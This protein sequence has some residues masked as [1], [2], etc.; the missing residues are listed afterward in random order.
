MSDSLDTDL[1]NIFRD[2]VGEY[3]ETLNTLLMQIETAA[4]ADPESLRELNRVAHSMKGAS[5]AVGLKVIETIA[6][7]M[8]EVFAASMQHQ[9]KL[10]PDVCDLLYDGLDLIQTVVDGDENDEETLAH[11][12]MHL[13]QV[14]AGSAIPA[15]EPVQEAKEATNHHG[16]EPPAGTNHKSPPAEP[17]QQPA[18]MP[19]P[20]SL[21]TDT[22]TVMMRPME[23][24]IRVSV[25]KLDQLMAEV[26][27]LLVAR[28]QSE[29]R[30]RDVQSLRRLHGR[31]RREWQGIRAAY[32]R[33]ARRVQDEQGDLDA[34]LLVIFK[35]LENNQRNLLAATHQLSQLVQALGQDNLRL[36]TLADQ[37]QDD[38]SR[39]RMVAF[40]T[41]L[42]GF[43]RMIRDLARDTGKQI[44][45]DVIG[46]AVEVD[47]TVLDALR[48]PIMHLLRNAVDHGVERPDERERSGKSRTGRV[49]LEIEQ[50]GNEIVLRVADD[51]KGIDVA[52]LRHKALQTGIIAQQ[53]ADA[54]SDE[55][56]R[57]LI[58]HPG[59][60]TAAT[61]TAISGRGI[62]M[63]VVRDRVESL[64]GRVSV[65]SVAGEGTTISLYVPV[66][67]TRIRC[68][69]LEIGME[70]Y[71]IPSAVIVRMTTL[72]RDDVF[73]A[74]NRDMIV[75]DE[76]PVPLVSMADVLGIPGSPRSAD[77][78]TVM[79]MRAAD[80][81]VAFEVDGLQSERELVLKP[82]G[83]EIARAQFVSGAAL[84]GTG[85]VI[86]V[87]DAN[88]VVRSATGRTLPARRAPVLSRPS[89]AVVQRLRI[90]VV[91][92]SITT[93]TLEK[94]I[95]ET[96]GFAVSVAIDG[97]E[98]WQK[99]GEEH[100][101]VIISDV[102]MPRV[103]GLE[104]VKLL[105][106]NEHTRH[107][108]VILL[109]SLAKPEHREAGLKAGADAYLVKSQFDQGELLQM[110]QA[111][112]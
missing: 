63:D 2:E 21:V 29:E 35:F 47:K 10:A 104:L 5:R 86:I 12:L 60:T 78:I 36:T 52:A 90:L 69:L 13:E 56:V 57:S 88:D 91:D 32:I 81:T 1:L 84:L 71:A 64:R 53:E 83:P 92:D 102:E 26:S 22:S 62:G 23:E 11:L 20:P 33:L 43:Q 16:E 73:T 46:L 67:L 80:R 70:T 87:L 40:E 109:T 42:G 103:N 18:E 100:F 54:M 48:D 38:V 15:D 106:G 44:H 9:L 6:H 49:R 31:W 111:V 55:D 30:V 108:P 82:L 97:D 25:G 66:S 24:S 74:E 65:M 95:L 3:L 77:E 75:L 98:A 61:V 19:I 96:A 58:F 45:L 94:N 39:M 79:A 85:A 27:E 59:L 8:E 107:I 99:I 93:R 112:M 101:D 28:M 50:R 51:G 68:V 4:S 7:Y 37:L 105:K 41:L 72:R 110:I 17:I 89:A 76:H 14:V 34:D